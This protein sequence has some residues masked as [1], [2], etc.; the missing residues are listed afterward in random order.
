MPEVAQLPAVIIE[1]NKRLG[2]GRRVSREIA[3]KHACSLTVQSVGSYNLLCGMLEGGP[4]PASGNNSV[5][6]CDLAKVEVVGS[7]PISR[8][9]NF[10]DK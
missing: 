6:E 10:S 3:V 8:S 5:V 4:A 9:I 7:N 2:R 1:C